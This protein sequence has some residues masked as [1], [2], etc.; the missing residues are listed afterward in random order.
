[1][2]IVVA[3]IVAAVGLVCYLGQYW[4]IDCLIGGVR[5][6]REAFCTL[7]PDLTLRIRI[8]CCF[9]LQV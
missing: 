7:V 9:G 5:G 1:V 2:V 8:R 3:A 4:M 6:K